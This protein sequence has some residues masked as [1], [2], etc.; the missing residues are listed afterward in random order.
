M[1]CQVPRPDH[2][3]T[4]SLCPACCQPFSQPVRLEC[5]HVVCQNCV[6]SHTQEAHM[7]QL[8][9]L[10]SSQPGLDRYSAVPFCNSI[11]IIC[12]VQ[13]RRVFLKLVHTSVLC[14][15]LYQCHYNAWM[16]SSRNLDCVRVCQCRC[17]GIYLFMIIRM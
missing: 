9:A 6:A 16:K 17:Y 10:Q 12:V 14:V 4:K 13:V 11:V 7:Q 15:L 8:A 2:L 5:S 3:D 1:F